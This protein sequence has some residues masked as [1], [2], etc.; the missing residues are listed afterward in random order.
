M[1]SADLS[2]KGQNY[3]LERPNPTSR[4]GNLFGHFI[5]TLSLHF[6]ERIA[7]ENLDVAERPPK[8]KQRFD[9]VH[10]ADMSLV[11][12]ENAARRP[13][14]KVSPLGRI[15]RPLKIRPIHPLTHLRDQSTRSKLI[16]K[17]SLARKGLDKKKKKLKF[18]D[19]RAK[20]RTIDMTKWG[21]THLKGNFLDSFSL[22]FS[23][24]KSVNEVET[25]AYRI[26]EGTTSSGND[27]DETLPAELAISQVESESSLP[28]QFDL[29]REKAQTLNFLGSL[30]G[31]SRD[32]D[33]WIGT[34][35]VGSVAEIGKLAKENFSPTGDEPSFEEVPRTSGELGS[36]S[37]TVVD[38]K[39]E[40][41]SAVVDLPT[42]KV[43]PAEE[44]TTT[45][46]KDLFAP[47]EEGD[48]LKFRYFQ[49]YA[50]VCVPLVHFSLLDHLDLDIALDEDL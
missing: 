41:Q 35:S 37:R 48:P 8:K 27:G 33:D 5:L 11:T 12:A 45:K 9:A 13:G 6:M 7:R 14:W 28:T 3:V 47:R 21:S 38:S 30:F 4:K 25:E 18:A 1:Y 2:G 15:T 16:L 44:N 19:N 49:T 39:S 32:E 34:E 46:L 10:A 36:D 29:E 40:I 22:P 31:G 42:M 50:D 20:R 43:T 17:S 26:D 23:K 24:D